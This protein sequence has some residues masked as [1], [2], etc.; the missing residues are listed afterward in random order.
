MVQ[1]LTSLG[2]ISRRLEFQEETTP[3]EELAIAG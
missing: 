1:K 2:D 3:T